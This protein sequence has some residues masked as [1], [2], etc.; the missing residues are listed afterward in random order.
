MTGGFPQKTAIYYD[1]TTFSVYMEAF[2][3]VLTEL[4]AK[5]DELEKYLD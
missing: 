1:R 2:N 3:L 4:A 5:Y